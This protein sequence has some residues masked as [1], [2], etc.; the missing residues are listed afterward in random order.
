MK[1]KT[2]GKDP[3]LWIA[4][5]LLTTIVVFSICLKTHPLKAIPLCVSCF[6]MLLQSKVN[7]YSFLLGGLNS[8]LYT[9]SY[10]LMDLHVSAAYALLVSF[11][12]QL[13]SFVKWNQ[14]TQNGVTKTK[15]LNTK[16]RIKIFGLIMVSCIVLYFV[17][18]GF[19][20]PHL[21]PDNISSVLGIVSTVLGMLRY[22][23]YALF[24]LIGGMMGLVRDVSVIRAD[25]SNLVNIF[26]TIYALS[27]ST[28]SFIRMNKQSKV[29]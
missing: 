12:L 4:L 21:V 10:V 5:T 22:S 24:Q 18:M 8:I 11:P 27:C 6:V 26:M 13:I 1:V 17:F 23:E 20:S 19:G 14:N 3:M 2:L 29:V 25:A 16:G 15:R 28:I 7:R 9:F